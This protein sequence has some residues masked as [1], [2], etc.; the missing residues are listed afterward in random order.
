MDLHVRVKDSEA[1]FLK[2]L[3]AKF[4]FVSVKEIQDTEVL[5]SLDSSI[6]QMKDMK[7]GKVTKPYYL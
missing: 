1:A 5:E 6:K 7:K 3:L 4:D 2:E